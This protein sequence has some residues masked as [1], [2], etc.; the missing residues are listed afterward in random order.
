MADDKNSRD[1][2]ARDDKKRQLEREIDEARRRMGEPEPPIEE[3]KLDEIE[4]D[5]DE[6]EF[7]AAGAEVVEAVGEKEVESV[8]RRYSV[9]E[10]V[11]DTETEKFGSPS[12]VLSRIKSPTVARAMKRIVEAADTVPRAEVGD[13]QRDAYEKTLRE[14]KEIDA[15]DYDEGIKVVTDWIVE[16]IHEEEKIPSS[17]AVRRRAAEFCRANGYEIR[18]DEWLGV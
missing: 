18:N 11:S 5:L 6:M 7:P 10:L 16:Q 4:K 15:D 1:K 3:E 2:Q 12:V 14:L 17:R 8:A 9:E 13:S